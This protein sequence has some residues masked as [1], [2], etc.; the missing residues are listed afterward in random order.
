MTEED[1]T[2]YSEM[3]EAMWE[4][5]DLSYALDLLQREIRNTINASTYDKVCILSSRQIGKSFLA[6][7]IAIEYCLQ[8]PGSI[9][10]ILSATLKQTADIVSDNLSKI[11]LKA[12][13]GLITP[14]KSAYRWQVGDSSLRLGALE[15]AHVDGNRGGNAAL[16]VYEEGGF[17][18]SSD[19][20]YAI[21]S[22]LG[23]QLLRSGG[24]EIHLSTPSEDPFHHLHDIIR[25]QCEA[26]GTFFKYTVYDSPSISH[27]QIQ[28]AIERCGG[29]HTDAFRREYLA[30]VIRSNSLM[31]IPEFEEAKHVSAFDLPEYYKAA[32][33][34]DMGGI[35]DKTALLSCVW[36]FQS[37]RLLVWDEALFDPNTPTPVVVK[38]S[39][40]LSEGLNWRENMPLVYADVPGQLQIDL[41]TIYNYPIMVPLK[42]DRDAQINALRVL[43]QQGRIL[44]HPRCQGLI[45]N[46]KTGRYNDKRTDF[47]RHP[48]FGHCDPIMALVYG[49]RCIDKVTI[50]WPERTINF[51]K[52]IYL[53]HRTAKPAL[54]QVAKHLA[55][56]NPLQKLRSGQ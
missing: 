30:E 24:R 3:Y 21:D 22:V 5:G 1:I 17:V 23:P 34:W 26:N 42:D 33:I 28:K 55:P 2:R 48:L 49:N 53:P 32:I 44:V 47:E 29:R 41:A 45:G 10:R 7:I 4:R 9:V 35:K 25:P 43:F 11:I 12:P 18:S 36:D 50:P 51:E 16:L 13:P 15:R 56:Y 40:R 20:L 46:L 38:E 8:N 27:E 37:A 19:Y 39:Q 31:V 14:E 6:C 54:T 52:K